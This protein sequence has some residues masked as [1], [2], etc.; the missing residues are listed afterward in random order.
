MLK[1]PLVVNFPVDL[2]RPDPGILKLELFCDGSRVGDYALH[3]KGG[4]CRLIVETHLID[5]DDNWAARDAN[6]YGE[7]KV[8]E[9]LDV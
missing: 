6:A 5:G 8:T 1:V 9:T 7:L 4:R 3:R 2:D